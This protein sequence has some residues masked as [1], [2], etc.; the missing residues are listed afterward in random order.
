[1]KDSLKLV[2][3]ITLL[4]FVL[5]PSHV[6]SQTRLN[7]SQCIGDDKARMM[8][9]EESVVIVPEYSINSSCPQ[10]CYCLNQGQAKLLGFEHCSNLMVS[11]G[12]DPIGTPMYCFGLAFGCLPGCLCATEEEARVLGFEELC[13]NQRTECGQENVKYCFKVEKFACPV[14]CTCLSK[15]EASSK[16]LSDRCLDQAKLPILCEI[17]DLEKSMAKYCYKQPIQGL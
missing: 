1:M 8:F 7:S 3:L 5:L 11:C 10:G 4:T 12:T 6:F 17:V 13:Q 15:E 16:G 2:L 9:G 14:G